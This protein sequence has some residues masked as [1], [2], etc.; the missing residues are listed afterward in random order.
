[1][2]KNKG[3]KKKEV[4]TSTNKGNKN[5]K[6]TTSKDKKN[7]KV[8]V[9]IKKPSL[10]SFKSFNWKSNPIVK[11]LV[12]VILFVV[13]LALVD[14]GVQYLNN[15]HSVAVVNGSRIS[16]KEWDKRLESSYGSSVA[17]Q[18]ITEKV[19][20][21]E[22]DKQ[23]VSVSKEEID[24]EIGEV[25][26]N[27]GGQEVF[28]AALA[29]NNLTEEELRDNYKID[30]LI[31]KLIEP[32][33]KYT[34]SEVKEY[35]DQY[36][37][38]M[39]PTETEA[40]GEGETLDFETYKEKATEQ[41]KRSLASQNYSGWITE[42]MDKYDIQDNSTDKPS[43]GFLTLTRGL[44]NN[45]FKKEDKKEETKSEETKTEETTESTEETKE[46]SAE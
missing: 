44:I 1:M 37:A 29:A 4:S 10:D 6:D 2:A 9:K 45:L 40:L 41:Y 27:L 21:L 46:Q 30:L 43:Y 42:L 22:A 28:E 24:T 12:Y 34:E 17:S 39:F 35:F 19:V 23:K 5:V 36:S 18:L 33:L 26:K 38:S 13:V 15:D 11:V 31:T 3:L 7:S 20:L 16:K 32:T 14:L 8:T 25:I